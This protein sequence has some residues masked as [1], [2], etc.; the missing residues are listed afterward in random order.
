MNEWDSLTCPH[1]VYG[2]IP[3]KIHLLNCV[4]KTNY[5]NTCSPNTVIIKTSK[6]GCLRDIIYWEKKKQCLLIFERVFFFLHLLDNKT[7]VYIFGTDVVHFALH[8][9]WLLSLVCCSIL[10]FL[11]QGDNNCVLSTF[12]PFC[13]T[14]TKVCPTG[15]IKKPL[16]VWRSISSRKTSTRDCCCVRN[17][18]KSLNL[19]DKI[20][21]LP[22]PSKMTRL[23][24]FNLTTVDKTTL[25]ISACEW[26]VNERL[27]SWKTTTVLSLDFRV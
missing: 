14:Q 7:G 19:N 8:K 1:V 11:S 27:L 4:E 24:V 15:N 9:S 13:Y 26:L 10:F 21:H 5:W 12:P 23:S 16:C 18:N 6:I 17:P 3:M 22:M 20:A 25:F 2:Y